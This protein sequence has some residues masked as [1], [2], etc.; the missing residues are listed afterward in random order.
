MIRE[1]APLDDLDTAEIIERMNLLMKEERLYTHDDLTLQKMSTLLGVTTHQL[2][3]I[4]NEKMNINFRSY[5]NSFR[6]NEAKT[7]LIEKPDLSVLEIAFA[8]GFNSKSSFNDLFLK[9]TGLSPREF[10]TQGKPR[11]V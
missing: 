3:W 1:S 8:T 9:T 11:S 10:R 2:S 5:L 4:I 6:V 7:M